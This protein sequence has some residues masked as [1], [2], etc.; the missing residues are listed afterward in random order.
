MYVNDAPGLWHF[1]AS[2]PSPPTMYPP[3]PVQH[4]GVWWHE[5]NCPSVPMEAGEH[6]VPSEFKSCIVGA[7]VGFGVGATVSGFCLNVGASVGVS[8]VGDSVGTFVGVI[9][10]GSC[11]NVGASV[12]VSVGTLVLGGDVD[13]GSVVAATQQ[14]SEQ[15]SPF[16]HTTPAFDVS[17]AVP[18]LQNV[19]VA[20][21]ERDYACM[22]ESNNMYGGASQIVRR[23]RTKIE[24]NNG[25]H[26]ESQRTGGC[27]G[28][29]VA[30]ELKVS[31]LQQ[32]VS[33]QPPLGHAVNIVS[34]LSVFPVA[35]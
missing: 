21:V 30:G 8:R 23:I 6:G 24:C 28:V 11:L 4:V 16:G 27:T 33:V 13:G 29:H 3:P 31:S 7:S 2:T 9:V 25:N 34:E 1:I 32:C 15:L 19:P 22:R 18:A 5:Y 26:L 10:S 17:N 14:N 12:G 35:Q 20:V